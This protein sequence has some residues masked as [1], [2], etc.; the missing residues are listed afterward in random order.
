MITKL[1]KSRY[2][3]PALVAAGCVFVVTG[4][5]SVSTISGDYKSATLS[6]SR[7]LAIDFGD[8]LY[9]SDDDGGSFQLRQDTAALFGGVNEEFESVEAL[10]STALAVG[11][12]GLILR[13]DDGGLNWSQATA[14]A[15][16]GSLYA[17]AGRSDGTNPNIWLAVGDDGLDGSIYKSTDDGLNWSV[18][19]V[20]TGMLIQDVIW[21]GSRWLFCGSDDFFNGVVY[22][23][24]D[25]S[26][27]T[28]STVPSGAGLLALATDG[29]G[30]VLAVGQSGRIL[31]STDDGLT[32]AELPTSSSGTNDFNAVIVDSN[33][34]FYVGGD[35]K[36]IL[37]ISGTTDT[38]LV[39]ATPDASPVL[40]FILVDDAPVAIGEL[41]VA[42]RTI[43]FTLTI[44]EGGAEDFILTVSQTLEGKSYYV[45]TTDDLTANDWTVVPGTSVAGT[46]NAM[47]FEVS[48][49]VDQRFWRV[50]EF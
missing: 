50:V 7:I 30:V 39:P 20:E 44:A 32:F 14:P 13:S 37:Q 17:A 1:L 40:D 10:G 2:R 22:S 31:R 29:N 24:P 21:T 48:E 28:A 6:G 33:G 11:E 35:E 46:G 15:L 49:D 25:G 12:D 19:S 41:T 8:D 45:E 43:P 27:W 9:T 47:T 42:T 5:A 23:S 36:L 26:T 3:F 4:N 18:A 38:I 34:D 16:L